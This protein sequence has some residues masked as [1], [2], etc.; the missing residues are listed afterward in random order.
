M[1]NLIAG[2]FIVFL[3][4]ILS[5]QV[6]ENDT[7]SRPL[8]DVFSN[9]SISIGAGQVPAE[10]MAMQRS[11][12]KGNINLQS[13]LEGIQQ[14]AE[15]QNES[16]YR[17]LFPWQFNGPLNIGGRITDIEVH[18]DDLS[19]WYIGAASGGI[20]KTTDAGDSWGFIFYN[21]PT[22]SIGD[23]AIDPQDNSVIY[24][25]T[26]EAN[27]SSYSFFGSGVYKSVDFGDSWVFSGLEN[28]AYIGRLIV[29]YSNS[30][31]IFAAACGNLF[32]PDEHRGIYRS[33][34]AGAT[35]EKVLFVS[36]ST[37]GI[38]I[39][40]HPIEPDVLYAGMWERMRGL[41]YRHSFGVTTGV[42]KSMDG[43]DTWTE[44]TNGLP[45]GDNVGR[46]GLA[47]AKSNPDV[48]YAF[49]DMQYS[50]I[51][52]YRSDN[53]GET[54]VR[55]NDG[56]L[57]GMN[58]SFGW[59]FGQVRVDPANEDRVFVLGVYSFRSD[60]GG[61]SWYEM[62]GFHVDHHA[63]Y[64]DETTGFCIE[65][66]DGGLYVSDN[67]GNSWQK[68]NNLP[69]TQFYDIE[70]DYLFPER[71][72]GGTQDNNTIRTVTGSLDDWH[73]ILG[74]DGFYT[75]VD[76]TDPTTIFAEYQWGGLHKST[77]MGGSF[78]YIAWSMSGDR[79]NWSSPLV[80]HPENPSVL[81][82][83]TYRV[84]KSES[85]GNSWIAVSNDLTDGDDGSTFHTVSTLAISPVNPDIVLAGTDDGHVHV[86]TNGGASWEEISDGLPLRWIT[87]VV[88]D[89]FN[90]NTIYVTVS[91]FRWDESTSHVYMSNNLG[92][93]WEPIGEGLPDIPV[94]VMVLD[95]GLEGRMFVGTDAGIFMSNDYGNYWHGISAGIGNVP[96]TALKIHKGNREL[97]AG[98]YG[99]S[100]WRIGL[101]EIYVNVPETSNQQSAYLEVDVY[102]N[103]IQKEDFYR[104]HVEVVLREEGD[105]F[106][107]LFN[108]SGRKLTSTYHDSKFDVSKEYDFGTVFD[109]NPGP[110]IYFLEIR[111]G[112]SK[113]MK[114]IVVI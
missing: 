5:I 33:D 37:S 6:D 12:P 45:Q 24:A 2:A 40:Q 39:V 60:N 110:G 9:S 38:D 71:V 27:A 31:R 61:N 109:I 87:R 105:L 77:N 102:P 28:S 88:A 8:H 1:K 80:M 79:T 108:V 10:W 70:V 44:L 56:V 42:Y 3:L 76:Y 100:A 23:L 47:I 114:K 16:E 52:V 85:G 20:L 78:D 46:V 73:A 82:F 84:W 64:I 66:N 68:I 36:D 58:S 15:L 54:W 50:E 57:Y 97:I 69:I 75:L 14:A 96:V 17:N 30:D 111:H 19:T 34:D 90:E 81:Y 101:D 83:G 99:L 11:W 72:Y 112:N 26:G 35:W 67:Y 86:S 91:G 62:G 22:I 89:P 106:I 49:Y 18:A 43:G 21:A 51:G 74:G 25:G 94:N 48:V 104:A 4:L 59:Y 93:T 65:G 92:S 95:P 41:N 13:Y 98:T 53:G 55:K 63:L 107:T 113:V 32:T 29:D 103:P 7:I